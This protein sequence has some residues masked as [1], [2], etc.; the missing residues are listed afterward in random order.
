M[1][2]SVTECKLTLLSTNYYNIINN[3]QG[4]SKKK[5][6][7]VVGKRLLDLASKQCAGS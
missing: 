5:A 3:T 2:T 6:A 4:M 7:R 1:G